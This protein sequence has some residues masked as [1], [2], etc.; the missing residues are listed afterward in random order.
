MGKEFDAVKEKERIVNWIR[1]WFENNGPKAG[2]VIGI[3]GGKDS[4]IAAAVLAEA[5]GPDRVYGVLM[6]DG[7]QADIADSVK[8]C[9]FLKINARIVNIKAATDGFKAAFTS[10]T[11]LSGAPVGQEMGTDAKI[12]MPPRIRDLYAVRVHLSAL[13]AHIRK[14]CR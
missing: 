14:F 5:L 7:E 9:E 4:T 12:N 1:K 2:A 11:D 3:S 6:P 13:R 10:A 8:V